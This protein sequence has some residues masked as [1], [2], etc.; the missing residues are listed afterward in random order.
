MNLRT[1]LV[2]ALA[3]AL[4]ACASNPPREG[5]APQASA[6]MAAAPSAYPV[7]CHACG[8]VV[9][10]D[11]VAG[12]RRTDGSGAVIGGVVGGVLGNQVGQGDGKTAATAAGVVAGA[13]VGNE[14]QKSANAAPTY[15]I[16]V[17]MDDGRKLILNQ[18]QLGGIVVGSYVDV[19][20]NRVHL[21]R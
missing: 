21:A 16:R 20:D 3:I 15:D 14:V 10:I 12:D 9:R 7:Q 2:S 17:Q 1:L 18:R 5:P 11:V 19:Y 13:V 6:P 4:G 8:H